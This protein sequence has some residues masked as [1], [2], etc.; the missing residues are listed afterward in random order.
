M[1]GEGGIGMCVPGRCLTFRV[2]FTR[3]HSTIRPCR[4]VQ[5]SGGAATTGDGRE[6]LHLFS[7]DVAYV[8]C[9]CLGVRALMNIV[10]A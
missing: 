2:P 5:Q 3:T 10:A 8:V 9:V 1:R 4:A 7:P 6:I